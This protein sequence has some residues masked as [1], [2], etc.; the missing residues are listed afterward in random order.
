MPTDPLVPMPINMPTFKG[1]NTELENSVTEPAW[2]VELNNLV[3]DKAGR[4]AA[5]KGWTKAHSTAISGSPDV[6]GLHAFGT[7]SQRD[8]I[9]HAGTSFY[10]GTSTLVDITGTTAPAA[11]D[12]WK[13]INFNNKCLAF[14]E[15][16]TPQVFAG[17]TFTDLSATQA[18]GMP[19]TWSGIALAA[20]GR[21]WTVDD[22]KTV[23]KYSGLLDET[24]FDASGTLSDASAGYIDL[25][26]VWKGG[27]DEITAIEAFNGQLVIFGRN[28]IVI[29][30]G[31][32]YPV[33]QMSLLENM[34]GIGCV[35]RDSVQVIGK[36]LWFLSG[37]GIR[38]L[39][40]TV[41]KDKMPISDISK[42]VHYLITAIATGLSLG[43]EVRSVYSESEAFYLITFPS[44]SLSFCFDIK[45]QL[46]DGSY[47]CTTWTDNVPTAMTTTISGKLYMGEAGY[48]GRYDG[49]LDD[50]ATY[51]ITLNSC[52]FTLGE[53]RYNIL[54]RLKAYLFA[55]DNFTFT[56]NWRFDFATTDKSYNKA[57]TVT[58][59]GSEYNVAE[60]NIGE[61]GGTPTWITLTVP[62]SGHGSFFRYGF[63]A[64]VNDFE[65][66][67]QKIDLFAKLGRLN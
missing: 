49:Y 35:A 60:Y 67:L 38:S 61:F 21:I 44:V 62:A 19:T 63:S 30:S 22:T 27:I 24:D 23:V 9:C 39:G 14:C 46:E 7:S 20:Y 36:D 57:L 3:F 12:N 42:N 50:T 25:T 15:G 48:I 34:Y 33:T 32:K 4:L 8:L 54:K 45:G 40:R 65:L 11:S 16:Y 58:Y 47:R 41:I 28:S 18:G 10:L 51:D 59:T 26:S 31:P 52:W 17:G 43:Q 6:R 56:V 53:N 37:S 13:F 29:Y 55:G 64:T 5:R 2:A 66:A 1:L